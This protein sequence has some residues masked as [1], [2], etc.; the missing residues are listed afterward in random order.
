MNHEN[1]VPTN[2]D[3]DDSEKAEYAPPTLVEYGKVVD[4]TGFYYTGEATDM[5]GFPWSGSG[6]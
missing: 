6:S 1:P 2:S 4:L 5:L 3:H